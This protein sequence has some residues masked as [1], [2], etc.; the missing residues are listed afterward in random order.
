MIEQ[1]VPV[2]EPSNN[3]LGAKPVHWACVNGHIAIVDILSQV[4]FGVINTEMSGRNYLIVILQ[5][6]WTEGS[7]FS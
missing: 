2:D 4:K 6:E 7:R 3:D 1:K 5:Y